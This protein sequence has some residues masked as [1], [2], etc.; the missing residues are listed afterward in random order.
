M[1]KVPYM[2][3]HKNKLWKLLAFHFTFKEAVID[4]EFSGSEIRLILLQIKA[5]LGC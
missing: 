3:Y 5:K 4:N 1:P 2:A